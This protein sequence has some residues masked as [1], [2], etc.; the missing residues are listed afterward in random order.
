MHRLVIPALSV[1]SFGIGGTLGTFYER[2][3][4][5]LSYLHL[6]PWSVTLKLSQ[7]KVHEY[8]RLK[9]CKYLVEM[10]Q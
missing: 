7:T 9:F 2:Y 1:V 8:P 4:F 3:S 10:I 6:F 5:S